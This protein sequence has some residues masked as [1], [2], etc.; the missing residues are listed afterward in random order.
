MIT[1][2]EKIKLECKYIKESILDDQTCMEIRRFKPVISKAY[3]VEELVKLQMDME[4]WG[5]ELIREDYEAIYR[6][7]VLLILWKTWKATGALEPEALYT[8]IDAIESLLIEKNRSYGDSVLHPIKMFANADAKL[9]IGV[10][11]DDKLSRI[12]N[13]PTAF[14]EDVVMDLLGYFILLMV[15]LS[16]YK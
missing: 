7:V 4:F 1:T 3:T 9:L 5:I 14:G 16:E 15:A 8:V 11:I 13:N 10:R 6:L 12:I 2:A